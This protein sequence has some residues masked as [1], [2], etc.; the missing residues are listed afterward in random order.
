LWN[1][2]IRGKPI[3]QAEHLSQCQYLPQMPRGVSRERLANSQ[4]SYAMGY[5]DIYIHISSMYALCHG[6]NLYDHRRARSQLTEILGMFGYKP[7]N[8]IQYMYGV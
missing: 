5:W 4:L 2:N 6:N 7:V 8:T 3:I 1:D